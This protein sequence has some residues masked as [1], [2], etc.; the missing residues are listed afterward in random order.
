MS[1]GGSIPVSAIDLTA[2][3]DYL[4]QVIDY[5]R[6]EKALHDI[7]RRNPGKPLPFEADH[8]EVPPRVRSKTD[9]VTRKRKLCDAESRLNEKVA[10]TLAKGGVALPLEDLCARHKLERF[11][12]Y[13]LAILLAS[14]MDPIM[15]RALESLNDRSHGTHEIRTILTILCDSTEERIRARRY[16]VHNAPLL[17]C[18]LLNLGYSRDMGSETEFMSMDLALPRRIASLML[19]EQDTDDAILAF[20]SVIDP[21]IRM[22]QVVLPADKLAEVR[23][24]VH[25]RHEY[26]RVRK[27]WGFDKILSYGR[28]TVIMFS[29]PPGTGKTMLAHALA[30]EAGCR[31]MLADFRQIIEH[32]AHDFAENF[33]RIFMEARI[34]NAVLFFDEADEMFSDRACN[35]AMPTLLRELEKMDGICILATNRP[36]I[37]DEALDRRILYRLDFEVPPPD[38]REAIWRKHIPEEAGV[39]SDVDCHALGEEFECSGG[40]IKNAVL[41]ALTQVLQRPE[42]EC[43]ITH[44]DLRSA[45]RQQLCNRMRSSADL[46]VPRAGMVDLILPDKTRDQIMG[47]VSAA[48]QRQRVFVSWGFGTIAGNG[49]GITA[50]FSG[51]PGAGKS[52][53]AEAVAH[54]LGY[55]LRAVPLKRA[56]DGPCDAALPEAL[57]L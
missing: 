45:A 56:G 1:T 38:L 44:A 6:M 46:V 43:R 47:V 35:G 29:G 7:R 51:E 55:G 49:R 36:Q 37:L 53:A 14:D 30:N 34:L 8:A 39:A 5:R 52:L 4:L 24:L 26:L 31:L 12:K 16:F 50:L 3:I 2:V 42:P 9:L 40:F 10:H 23:A 33:Q 21:E 57:A 18:G 11:E 28:G 15:L 27:A 48:R 25:N 41:T 17:A 13:T 20:S 32:S 19:G 54:E 22:D